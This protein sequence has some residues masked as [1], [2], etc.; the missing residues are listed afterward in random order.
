VD[1]EKKVATACQPS[2]IISDMTL[3]LDAGER[4]NV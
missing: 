3:S 4:V 2:Q 1:L